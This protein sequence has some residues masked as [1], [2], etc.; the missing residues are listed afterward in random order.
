[1]NILVVDDEP[2]VR[3]VIRRLLDREFEVTI[4]EA[5]DGLTAL[6]R[7]LKDPVDLVL[8]DLS[9]KVMSGIETLEAIRRSDTYA[10][11]PVVLM[12]AL[13]DELYVRRAVE[14][15]IAA[16]IV[17]PFTPAALCERMAGIISELQTS[18]RAA[19]AVRFLDVEPSHRALIVDQSREFLLRY[20]VSR[21]RL[22][23]MLFVS[24]VTTRQ[25]WGYLVLNYLIIL[26]TLGLGFPW[27]LHRTMRL[28]TDQLW[29]YGAPDARQ[30]QRTSADGSATGE[31]LLDL[32]SPGAV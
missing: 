16:F 6:D 4:L 8:L 17:K 13:A 10:H 25:M 12:T 7:L 22:A 9:M 29:I 18:R 23:G 14:L 11:L 24:G 1:M 31:G 27:V 21:T 30:I 32:L 20:L 2:A 28:I 15:G 26:L 3:Q 19:P 5:D